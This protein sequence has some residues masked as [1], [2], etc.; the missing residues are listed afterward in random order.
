MNKRIRKAVALVL[1]GGGLSAA[2]MLADAIT[3]TGTISN[4]VTTSASGSAAIHSWDG[5]N[6]SRETPNVF[7]GTSINLG[8]A[9]NSQWYDLHITKPGNYSLSLIRTNPDHKPFNPAFSLWAVGN[10]PFDFENCA[11]PG[12][13]GDASGGGTHSYNQVSAPTATNANAWMLGPNGPDT[14]PKGETLKHTLKWTP[15]S[16]KGAVTGFIGYANSG[17]GGWL[18]GTPENTDG[19]RYTTHQAFPNFNISQDQNRV[20]QGGSVNKAAGGGLGGATLN[21][22]SNVNAPQNGGS[23]VMNLYGLAAG[24]YLLAMG[25]SCYENNC[26]S[27]A[28]GSYRLEIVE[29]ADAEKPHAAATANSPVRAGG[30]VTLNGNSSFDPQGD[31]LTY[32]WKQKADDVAQV[33]LSDSAAAQPSFTAPAAAAGKTLN[34]TLTVTDPNGDQSSADVAVAITD[35]NNPPTVSITARPVLEDATV[36]LTSSASD[37]DGDQIASYL[38]TQ[39]GGTPVVLTKVDGASLSFTAPA[40]AS[41]SADLGFSLK[42]TDDY[43]ANPQSTTATATL[44]VNNDSNL[45]DCA[46]ATAGPATLDKPNKG[47][48]PVSIAGITGPNAFSLRITGIDSDEPI[49]DK[50]AKDRT[51][52]DAKIVKGKVTKK[53]PVAVDSALLRAERQASGDGRV[54]TLKFTAS[55]GSQT[56]DGSAKV[57]V[58][59]APGGA[60]VEGTQAFNALKKK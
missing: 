4:V 50:A 41:G 34:F 26:G 21:S 2:P 22:A 52:P 7:N 24:H 1:A 11:K 59:V 17:S 18:N 6:S 54:Y 30:V 40:V 8:W 27:L 10:A 35:D 23:A 19:G 57:R 13:C 15:A 48:K 51:G 38:W 58:P 5:V 33:Q 37:P 56:C 32:A 47:M 53:K 39:T 55:D 46:A 44:T 12:Q 20:E 36:T 45:L 49:K 43:A 3:Q 31:S 28:A 14:N 29:I 42:V 16:G 9:H 60:A 25:G